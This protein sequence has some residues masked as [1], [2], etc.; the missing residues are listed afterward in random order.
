MSPGR[1]SIR[2]RFVFKNKSGH[3]EVEPRKVRL[4]AV[5]SSQKAGID[6]SETFA[7][8]AKHDSLIIALSCAA[9]LDLFIFVIDV[10]VHS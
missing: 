7:S 1:K 10:H 3:E 6:Y 9:D 4:V 8:V 2:C 5:G